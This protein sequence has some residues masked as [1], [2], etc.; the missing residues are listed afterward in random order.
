M[1]ES[2]YLGWLVVK[3]WLGGLPGVWGITIWTMESKHCQDLWFLG[4]YFWPIP[5][6]VNSLKNRVGQLLRMFLAPSSTCVTVNTSSVDSCKILHQVKTVVYSMIFHDFLG[7]N[8]P[9]GGAGF[10]NHPQEM[11]YGVHPMMRILA[12]WA[13]WELMTIPQFGRG[14]RLLT[15]AHMEVS[16]VSWGSPSS[17]VGLCHGRSH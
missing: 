17:L 3:W 12:Q 11:W 4:L 10:R 8:H 14:I 16:M 9:F 5:K 2:R 1:E 13:Q 15:V 7:F 6:L